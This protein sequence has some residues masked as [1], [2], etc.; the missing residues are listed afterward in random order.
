MGDLLTGRT[1][2]PLT[3]LATSSDQRQHG[4]AVFAQDQISLSQQW[5]LLAGLRWDE[6]SQGLINRVA[7][8][9][10]AR[11]H[12]AVSPRAG[13]IYPASDCSSLY[14]SAQRSGAARVK[15]AL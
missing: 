5:K 8:T 4:T 2:P 9:P 13:L 11:T 10:I 15:L 12:S 7:Q 6:F 14:V 3:L 1:A